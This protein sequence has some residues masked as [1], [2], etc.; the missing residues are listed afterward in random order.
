RLFLAAAH[1]HARLQ[2]IDDLPI[3][4]N[5]AVLPTPPRDVAIREDIEQLNVRRPP[6]AA[7]ASFQQIMAQ[8]VRYWKSFGQ[9]PVKRVQFV[10]PFAVITAFADQILVNIR[11]GVR[12]RIDPARISKDALEPRGPRA[13]QRG[14]DAWLNDRVTANYAAA[15]RRKSRLIQRMRQGFDHCPGGIAQ[16]L[17][18]GIQRDDKSNALELRAITHAE[19]SFQLGRGFADEESVELLELAALA[20]PADPALL[21]LTPRATA[22][23]KKEVLCSVPAIQFPDPARHE[24]DRLCVLR[25][26]FPRRVSKI[27]QEREAQIGIRVSEVTNFEAVNFVL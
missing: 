24:V 27:G 14:A 2:P 21:A 20:F 3:A 25:H 23:K 15:I 17:G 1:G 19:E 9:E 10:N 22:M 26:A 4:A 7:M 8:E 12:V 16:E 5:P 18:I 11:N 6:H 13:R